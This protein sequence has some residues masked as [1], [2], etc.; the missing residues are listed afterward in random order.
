MRRYF[1]KPYQFVAPFRSTFWCRMARRFVPWRMRKRMQIL[2]WQFEGLEHLQQSYDADAGI[3]LV[4]N[5]CGLA[6]AV[7]LGLLGL[8]MKRYFY[9]LVSY[10]LFKQNR[11]MGWLIKRMGGYSIWREGADRESIRTTTGILARAER[12]VVIFPEGTWFKQNDRIGPLQ[13]GITLILRQAARESKR[14]IIIHPVA[15]KYWM[16]QD[17]RPVLEKR[18]ATLEKRL[19]WHPQ[20]HLDLLPRMEKLGQ[21]LLAVKEIEKFGEVQP[22][23]L[24]DRLHALGDAYVTEMEKRMFN[25]TYSGWLLERIRRLRQHLVKLLLEFT[26]HGGTHEGVEKDLDTL[27]LCENLNSHSFRYVK[28]RP[29]HERLV[30]TV[31]RLEESIDDVY[32][33]PKV[34]QGVV[35][36]VHP[37]LDIRPLLAG[38]EDHWRQAAESFINDL[39]ATMQGMIDRLLEK[40]PPPDWQ[41]PPRLENIG[42]T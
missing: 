33:E 28:E 13:E 3:M 19:T 41:C 17:P 7:V 26:K 40:G 27:L 8:S 36:S 30:E 23:W 32:E 20:Q 12:P 1:D 35:A 39:R 34:P 29:S 4:S 5:H 9:Y 42:K 16:L 38:S 2:R 15:L 37:G 25:R 11:L 6:D 14:P 22:G 18:L 24:D 31:L 21:A 10:H